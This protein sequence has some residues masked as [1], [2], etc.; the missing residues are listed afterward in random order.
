MSLSAGEGQSD[1]GEGQLMRMHD[2][3][4]FHKFFLLFQEV[5]FLISYAALRHT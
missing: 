2:K 5:I 1:V 3:Q 4:F